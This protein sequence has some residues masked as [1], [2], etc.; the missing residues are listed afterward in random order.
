MTDK[1]TV[2]PSETYSEKV[3]REIDESLLEGYVPLGIK[4]TR[5]QKQREAKADAIKEV[6]N[7]D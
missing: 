2:E 5:K 3:F 4:K 1:T 6:I 7:E